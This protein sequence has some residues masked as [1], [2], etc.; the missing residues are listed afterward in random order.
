MLKLRYFVEIT[1]REGAYTIC[2]V[3][4]RAPLGPIVWGTVGGAVALVLLVAAIF[5]WRRRQ[6]RK[7]K[8][9]PTTP[10]D[11][12]ETLHKHNPEASSHTPVLATVSDT[13]TLPPG[14]G[15]TE[16]TSDISQAAPSA[17]TA[18]VT[19]EMQLMELRADRM[20]AGFGALQSVAAHQLGDAPPPYRLGDPQT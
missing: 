19:V 1:H 11:D 10:I 13:P 12:I 18:A 17:A 14:S 15:Q 7:S 6:Q 4:P 3:G 16:R 5:V 8:H 20:L 2:G 9:E